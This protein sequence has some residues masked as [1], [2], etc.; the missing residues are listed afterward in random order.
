MATPH[1]KRFKLT[2]K[3]PD[4]SSPEADGWNVASQANGLVCDQS[5][6]KDMEIRLSKLSPSAKYALKGMT[7]LAAHS[8]E[9]FCLVEDVAQ[10]EKLPRNFLSKI[11][12]QLAHRGIL[13]SRRGP[14]GGYYLAKPAY[15]LHL[16]EIVEAVEEPR[17]DDKQC[18]LELNT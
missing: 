5:G 10:S 11:F 12:Q 15:Q 18:L 13:I 3:K 8:K 4:D 17:K 6:V 9:N 1:P 7:Y 16:L 14:G 2:M